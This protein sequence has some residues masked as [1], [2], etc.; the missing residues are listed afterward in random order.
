MRGHIVFF[1]GG[2]S[3]FP[4]PPSAGQLQ[5]RFVDRPRRGRGQT[6]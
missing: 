1:A 6:F 3:R 4:E 2:A 5:W